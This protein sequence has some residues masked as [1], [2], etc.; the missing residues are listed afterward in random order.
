MTLHSTKITEQAFSSFCNL[1]LIGADMN[2]VGE[3]L[4]TIDATKN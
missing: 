4:D 2:Q 3:Q 1:A